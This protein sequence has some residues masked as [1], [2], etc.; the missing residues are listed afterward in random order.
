MEKLPA[1]E[2][3]KFKAI[4]LPKSPNS[5]EILQFVDNYIT[6]INDLI[7]H[8]EGEFNSEE[9]FKT[10][11]SKSDRKRAIEDFK[12]K[13]QSQT[14]GMACCRTLIE[15]IVIQNPKVEIGV[16]LEIV[17]K[18]ASKYGVSG[19]QLQN[20]IETI[21]IFDYKRNVVN[22]IRKDYPNDLDLINS[23]VEPKD[24][25]VS[26][27]GIK[28]VE[29][30][31]GFIL[32]L[33]TNN[34][35]KFHPKAEY[36]G[37]F[38]AEVYSRL[39]RKD[40]NGND[41]DIITTVS[42]I[43]TDSEFIKSG[44]INAEQVTLHEIEHAKTSILQDLS[45]KYNMDTYKDQ[46]TMYLIG[47]SG[48]AEL[49]GLIKFLN[50]R[51]NNYV[52]MMRDKPNTEQRIAEMK[53]ELIQKIK[54]YEERISEIENETYL[55]YRNFLQEIIFNNCQFLLTELISRKKDG[56]AHDF[57]KVIENYSNFTKADE[58]FK[59]ILPDVEYSP[60]FKEKLVNLKDSMQA[61][62]FQDVEKANN[63]FDRLVTEGGYSVDEAISLLSFTPLQLWTKKINRILNT[64]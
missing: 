44:R 60:Q 28:I 7:P 13:L 37:G 27:E 8:F 52:E 54:D 35:K 53:Q 46:I 14:E 45:S 15:K 25:F 20:Y 57:K 23:M 39:K 16:L 36:T 22:E 18:F 19:K 34:A 4:E 6:D 29:S 3:R 63:S 51:Y 12:Q 24:M 47:R 59:Q 41:I 55:A 49:Q 58:F 26:M 32:Y 64:R 9:V 62:Y 11:K 38:S 31:F 48:I 61:K 43:L 33:I 50:K 10:I 17:N 56:A 2:T 40:K 5:E 30:P 21:N 42:V 1:P